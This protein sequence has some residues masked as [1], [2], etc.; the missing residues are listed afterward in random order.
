MSARV[1][2]KVADAQRRGQQYPRGK[3]VA[4]DEGAERGRTLLQRSR[5]PIHQAIAGCVLSNADRGD[6]ETDHG[7][8][9][10]ELAD[11]V[12]AEQTS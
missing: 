1:G 8:A 6:D 12:S 5:A 4:I 10:N 9:A 11:R 2:H 3:R 7:E